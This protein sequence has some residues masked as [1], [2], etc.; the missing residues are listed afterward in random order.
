MPR[1]KKKPLDKYLDFNSHHP[2][3][4]KRSVVSTLLERAEKVLSTSAGKHKG[5]KHVVKVLINNNP[6]RF[7]KSCDSHHKATDHRVS[8]SNTSD[9][10]QTSFVVLP[11]VK[12]VNERVSKVLRNNGVK[13]GFQQLNTLCTCFPRPKDKLTPFQS[14]SVVDNCLDCDFVYYGQTDRALVT[15]IKEHRRAIRVYDMQ[16]L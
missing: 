7:I 12:G 9:E 16:Q 2:I 15:R 5:K 1:F 14:R 3:Q 13:V 6:L 4:N 10:V 8:N 11:Y